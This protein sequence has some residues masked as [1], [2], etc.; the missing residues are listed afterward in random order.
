[1]PPGVFRAGPVVRTFRAARVLGGGAPFLAGDPDQPQ[2]LSPAPSPSCRRGWP[3]RRGRTT[4]LLMMN[5]PRA[6]RYGLLSKD[7]RV[8]SI[9]CAARGSRFRDA[10]EARIVSANHMLRCQRL[11][12]HLLRGRCRRAAPA[13]DHASPHKS[14][15]TANTVRRGH[16]PRTPKSAP[17]SAAHGGKS[18]LTAFAKTYARFPQRRACE[19]RWQGLGR[20]SG[21]PFEDRS[22]GARDSCSSWCLLFPLAK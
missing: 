17:S 16:T 2:A 8:I 21:R 15:P 22:Q 14:R 20:R 7:R 19:W 4:T 9:Y 1:M 6:A 18:P 3:V 12:Q 10:T 5:R 11:G 13:R